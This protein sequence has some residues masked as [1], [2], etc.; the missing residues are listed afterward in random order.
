MSR[1]IYH[2]TDFF[3]VGLLDVSR[4]A[5]YE[6]TL[7]Y[8][9]VF[10]FVRPSLSFFKIGS[11]VFSDIVHDNSW[12]CYLVTDVARFL[13]KKLAARIWDKWFKIWLKSRFFAI[14]SGLIH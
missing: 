5:S 12:P 2:L 10:L 11:L 13:Q 14:F 3:I 6:I 8:L 1:N 9:S 4:T 7:V